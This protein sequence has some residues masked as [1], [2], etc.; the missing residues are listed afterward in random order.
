M[1]N[2]FEF[3]V[4][5][6][7][8]DQNKPKIL[9][10]W[11]DLLQ[12]FFLTFNF[13]SLKFRRSCRVTETISFIIYAYLKELTVQLGT[14]LWFW[15]SFTLNNVKTHIC[16]MPQCNNICCSFWAWKFILDLGNKNAL[17]TRSTY[18]VFPKLPEQMEMVCLGRNF[19]HVIK[20]WSYK[21]GDHKPC[22]CSYDLKCQM[23]IFLW[24]STDSWSMTLTCSQW[25]LLV[26]A[27]GFLETSCWRR[28]VT[29][30]H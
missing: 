1:S 21:R 16:Y 12:A 24:P 17:H 7:K 13:K 3:V 6:V 27:A 29:A 5:S 11:E 8:Y 28:D 20:K 14:L 30:P 2:L 22:F 26:F 23:W 15:F 10:H 19:G 4:L 18:C 25:M 9:S